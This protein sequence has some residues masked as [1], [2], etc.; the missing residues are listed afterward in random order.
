M[1]T[2][3][4]THDPILATKHNPHAR[5]WVAPGPVTAC[6]HLLYK[7]RVSEHVRQDT[8]AAGR[9]RT[10]RRPGGSYATTS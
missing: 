7:G 6:G 4:S 1:P 2:C 8:R 10:R 3:R 9:R 5:A